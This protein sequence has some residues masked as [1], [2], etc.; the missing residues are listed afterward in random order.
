[1]KWAVKCQSHIRNGLGL[2]ALWSAAQRR[3]NHRQAAEP[4]DGH[5]VF[6]RSRDVVAATGEAEAAS[7]YPAAAEAGGPTEVGLASPA[8]GGRPY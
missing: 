5:L 2:R 4:K 6:Y 3:P 1:M 8:D 7:A